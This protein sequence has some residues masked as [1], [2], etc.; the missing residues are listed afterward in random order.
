LYLELK[1]SNENL[2]S[3]VYQKPS[4]KYLYLPPTIMI[5]VMKQELRR[6]CLYCTNQ[7][8]ELEIKIKFY[9]RLRLWGH[10]KTNLDPLF[11]ST[12]ERNLLVIE[13]QN[14]VIGKKGYI[15]I[16]YLYI[17]VLL[18]KLDQ[19]LSLRDFFRLPHEV[20]SHP[21]FIQVWWITSSGGS[22]DI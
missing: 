13:L 20:T 19:P 18:P 3:K 5:N 7:S 22:S 10:Q 17:I 9:D 14:S 6:Y 1:I 11:E 21:Y 15:N 2:I 4:K 8:D 12:L 16:Q